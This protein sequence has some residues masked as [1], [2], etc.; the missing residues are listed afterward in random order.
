MKKRP[1]SVILPIL[2]VLVSTESYS[3]GHDPNTAVSSAAV[4]GCA[5]GADES[6]QNITRA[7]SEYEVLQACQSAINKENK[8]DFWGAGESCFCGASRGAGSASNGLSD[9]QSTEQS[10]EFFSRFDTNAKVV[11]NALTDAFSK[12]PGLTSGE[13]QAISC[14]ALVNIGFRGMSVSTGVRLAFSKIKPS[15][16]TSLSDWET[17]SFGVETKSY[18]LPTARMKPDAKLGVDY[19]IGADGTIHPAAGKALSD[20]MELVPGNNSDNP[21]SMIDTYDVMP[22]QRIIIR[23]KPGAK[24]GV[25]YTIDKD[26]VI[27]PVKG[28]KFDDIFEIKKIE[29]TKVCEGEGCS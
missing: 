21:Q 8:Y 6:Y 28:K 22:Q 15:S 2:L 10:Y 20:L 24:P 29:N 16:S 5:A 14:Q 18:H 11:H 27:Q 12:Q 13:K 1:E 26:G 7:A 17:A 3:Q 4:D 23:L 19:T 25:D 9:V